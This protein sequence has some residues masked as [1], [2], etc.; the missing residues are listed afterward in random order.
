MKDRLNN[1]VKHRETFRPYAPAVIEEKASIYFDLDEPS[2]SMLRVIPVLVD[3]LPAITHVDGSA[4]VQ[5]VNKKQNPLFYKL[6]LALEE[7][8]GFP[9]V[10]NT[11]FNV[12]GEPI[13]ETP[14][15]AL[16][17]F[18]NSSA[19]DMLVLGAFVVE[20]AP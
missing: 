2:P 14:A 8:T 6:L 12:A 9:V 19:I 13:V 17:T 15:D 5:T 1:E 11:S 20:H 16:R 18:R 7:E 3:S 10:L 4:R